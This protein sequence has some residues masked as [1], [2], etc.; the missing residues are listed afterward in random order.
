MRACVASIAAPCRSR[1]PTRPRAPAIPAPGYRASSAGSGIEGG[2]R[3]GLTRIGLAQRKRPLQGG[4]ARPA[5]LS[6]RAS[7]AGRS[8][9]AAG[10]SVLARRVKPASSAS[11]STAVCGVVGERLRLALGDSSSCSHRLERRGA[12]GG[13]L[14]DEFARERRIVGG[15]R[16]PRARFEQR[17]GQQIL[18][19]AARRSTGAHSERLALRQA[20]AR[21]RIGCQ[22]VG[23]AAW[24]GARRA[25]RR[26][27]AGSVT[28]ADRGRNQ[29]QRRRCARLASH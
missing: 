12:L 20:P 11:G 3:A 10:A 2:D 21:E 23:V 6:G 16:G 1:R 14:R 13:N 24:R 4:R 22:M 15:E 9:A 25:D 8:A 29:S 27:S 5:S 26:S 17:R 7:S 28:S 18:A 19:S